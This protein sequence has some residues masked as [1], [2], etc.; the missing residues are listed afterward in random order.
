VPDLIQHPD[1]APGE[2]PRVLVEASEWADRQ[3][4]E[5]MLRSQG[6]AT[7]ACPGPEGAGQRCSLAA[8]VGCRAAEEADVVVHALR[9]SDARNREALL[10]LRQRLPGTP[11]VV[12]V[13]RAVAEE[14]ARDYEGC[15]VVH[16]P[17]TGPTLLAA[18]AEALGQG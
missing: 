16:T 5:Q 7:V 13:P 15:V 11:V 14:R 6:Y 8:G 3:V 17:V 18:V 10:A 1:W 9:P 12:E 2:Q 4:I